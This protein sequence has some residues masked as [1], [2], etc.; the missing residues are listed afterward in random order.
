MKK[1]VL[2]FLG[3]LAIAG[4]AYSADQNPNKLTSKEKAAGWRPAQL[5]GPS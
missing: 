2:M 4:M 3:L 1:N 5:L